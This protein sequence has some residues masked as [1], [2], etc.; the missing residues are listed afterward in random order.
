MNES[1]ITGT[2]KPVGIQD[3]SRQLLL[4]CRIMNCDSVSFAVSVVPIQIRPGAVITKLKC[5]RCEN[6]F[7]V[8]ENG[9]I[10]D[11][12]LIYKDHQG[13]SHHTMKAE[14]GIYNVSG[15]KKT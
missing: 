7:I 12:Q 3:I 14:P 13:R 9:V 10:G 15:P 4:H 2:G 1:Q 5:V 11:K 8:S 6:E